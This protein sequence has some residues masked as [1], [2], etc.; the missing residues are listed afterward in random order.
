M[1]RLTALICALLLF[2]WAGGTVSLAQQNPF[3]PLP[4][5]PPTQPPPPQD[6]GDNSSSSDEDEGLTRRTQLLIALAGAVLLV[7]IGYAIVRDARS[8]A[9]VL[10]HRTAEEG[11]TA[12]KGS[13][14]PKERRVSQGRARAKAARQ[15]RK[16]ARKK[17]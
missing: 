16:K 13:R 3:A 2:A 1:A 6:N 5:P 8:A 9:P 4:T 7:G 15:A 14:T 12:S 10:H 11:G 17:R